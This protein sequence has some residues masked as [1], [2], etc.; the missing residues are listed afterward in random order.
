MIVIDV[1]L[2]IFKDVNKANPTAYF[3]TQTGNQLE[4]YTTINGILMRYNHQM[5]GTEQDILFME[6]HFHS[7][8][9]VDNISHLN[10]EPWRILF[11]DIRKQLVEIK[12]RLDHVNERD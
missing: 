11:L 6:Q 5:L 1:D 3:Y 2:N 7:A 4:L 10:E 12:E 9:K 8:I